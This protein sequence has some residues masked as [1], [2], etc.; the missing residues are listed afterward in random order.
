MESRRD[1]LDYGS[2]PLTFDMLGI[3]KK[4]RPAV[5]DGLQAME[6]TALDTWN[7]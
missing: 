2:L 4:D 3:R 6:R 7:E 1:G 5:F